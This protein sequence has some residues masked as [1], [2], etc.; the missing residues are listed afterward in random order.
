VY[1]RAC[2]CDTATMC[3]YVRENVHVCVC[4]CM[5][6]KRREYCLFESDRG[7][8]RCVCVCVRESRVCMR[9]YAWVGGW[10]RERECV[11]A[12]ERVCVRVCV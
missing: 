12:T 5:C 8:L 11:C 9:A 7:C 3:L 4:V 6:V 2:V 1:V 10:V